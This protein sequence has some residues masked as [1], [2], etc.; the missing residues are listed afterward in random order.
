MKRGGAGSGMAD[1]GTRLIFENDQ[2]DVGASRHP[3][4]PVE[5]KARAG[6]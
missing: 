6:R 2:V 4:I 3:A 1:A 5:L